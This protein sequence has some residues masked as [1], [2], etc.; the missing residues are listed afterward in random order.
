MTRTLTLRSLDIPSIAKFG[1]GFDKSF[2]ELMQLTEQQTTNY[3][4]YNIVKQTETSFYVEVAVAGFNQGEITIKLENQLLS[5]TGEKQ[6][7]SEVE[8]LHRGI[9]N[10]SFERS[11]KLGEHI[12]VV[13]AQQQNGILTVFLEQHI[14]EAL[15]PKSIDIKYL[16]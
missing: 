9:S 4:P 3:P 7:G 1:I 15:K 5:I 14:P 12:E 10:R 16:T 6:D 13:D 2:Q 11:F 8:Y